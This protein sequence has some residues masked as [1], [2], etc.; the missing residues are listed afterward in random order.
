MHTCTCDC[1]SAANWFPQLVDHTNPNRGTFAQRW[2]WDH[3]AWDGTANSPVL[4]YICGEAPCTGSPSGSV[5]NLAQQT[6]SL[7]V[8]LE[9]RWYGES[10]PGDITSTR[11]LMTLDVDQV[12]E[13]IPAFISYI[14]GLLGGV[15][16]KWVA[17]GG[18][19]P[20]ALS[21]W[22][23]E[24]RPDVIDASWSSSGVVNA[25]YKFTR[26]DQLVA[27]AVGTEC[28]NSIRAVTAAMEAAWPNP[29]AR[30]AM[31]ALFGTPADFTQQDFAWMLA[32]SA[33]MGYVAPPRRA[34]ARNRRRVGTRLPV[35]FHFVTCTRTCPLASAHICVRNTL[36]VCV[37]VRARVC[38]CARACSAQYGFKDEMCSY[39]VPQPA[40]VLAAFANWTNT[41]YGATF[42]A[43]C[44][45]STA[46][47][48]DP[49]RVA[50]WYDAKTWV[51]QCCY[52]L[53]RGAL[54]AR[55]STPRRGGSALLPLPLPQR[56]CNALAA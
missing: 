46:C 6:K 16:R 23:R 37:C 4:F 33:A 5:I 12:M 24:K 17:I 47:L 43:S 53:V 25:V 13:D 34:C 45:Y 32:D 52:Q 30:A 55:C 49:K 42:G 31:L 54:L 19:Y 15:D 18:S 7:I 11:D 22:I 35:F 20:G 3:S 51:W 38:V 36:Y 44:Y 10:L 26:F 40:N 21:A 14:E 8:A 27:Q 56:A 9:H 48:S 2:Y 50:E 39:L 28:A 41:H 29:T 1:V